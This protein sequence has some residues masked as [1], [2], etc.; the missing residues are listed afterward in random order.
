MDK[1]DKRLIIGFV[2]FLGV[3]AFVFSAFKYA[4]DNHEYVFFE[5]KIN[6]VKVIATED[7]SKGS[8]MRSFHVQIKE[9]DICYMHGFI[10]EKYIIQDK[11][12]IIQIE[13]LELLQD[14]YFFQG[15]SVFEGKI[16]EYQY[17]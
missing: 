1:T 5:D 8:E 17:K 2:I 6:Q 16:I 11:K 4:M 7:V 10:F 12:I 13:K 15:K 14:E 9:E 3:L